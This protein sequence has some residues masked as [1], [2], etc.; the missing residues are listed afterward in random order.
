[1]YDP[2]KIKEIRQRA[3]NQFAAQQAQKNKQ[4]LQEAIKKHI[5]TTMIFAI[6][7]L[8][9]DFGE[10][11]GEELAEGTVLNDTQSIW[12]EKFEKWRK[13]VL[14]NGNNQLR[15]ALLELDKYNLQLGKLRI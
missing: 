13:R 14:D 15:M 10:L 6:A 2:D 12:D 7:Q 9:K 3:D 1:M 4:K 8:E 11:W 5:L